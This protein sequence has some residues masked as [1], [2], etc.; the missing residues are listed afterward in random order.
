M[1]E[2]VILSKSMHSVVIHQKTVAAT[3]I[4]I[5][6]TTVTMNV[7]FK[8]M[9][10]LEPYLKLMIKRRVFKFISGDSELKLNF[11][12]HI[13]RTGTSQTVRGQSGVPK[14]K[15]QF[16]LPRSSSIFL[17]TVKKTIA[18]NLMCAGYP[19]QEQEGHD[20]EHKKTLATDSGFH[21][22]LGKCFRSDKL[23]SHSALFSFPSNTGISL[24]GLFIR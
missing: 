24:Q 22:D 10:Q 14:M 3:Q 19:A 2:I 12:W 6:W 20:G 23:I 18:D 4:S 8:K 13:F 21:S 9:E 5:V 7:N 17:K 1:V 11:V 15:I 16:Q